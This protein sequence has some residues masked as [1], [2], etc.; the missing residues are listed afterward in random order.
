MSALHPDFKKELLIAVESEESDD[1]SVE[2]WFFEWIAQSLGTLSG[3]KFQMLG[4]KPDNPS[5]L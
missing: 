2:T 3:A 4:W 1:S 5:A